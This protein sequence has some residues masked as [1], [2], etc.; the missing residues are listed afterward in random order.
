MKNTE[1]QA[2][3]LLPPERN[4]ASDLS[5]DAFCLK[6]RPIILRYVRGFGNHDLSPE[7]ITQDVLL[8]AW[9]NLENFRGDSSIK[10][11][12]LSIARR[13]ISK[14]LKRLSSRQS[15]LSLDEIT[16]EASDSFNDLSHPESEVD[17]KEIIHEVR[18]AISQLTPKQAQAVE[19]FY[20][21]EMPQKKAAKYANCP[22]DTFKNRLRRARHRLSKLLEHMKG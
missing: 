6:Y 16:E 19:L 14:R 3:K 15:P 22:F 20:F 21:K 13:C 4:L 11:Y 12:I 17:R 5:C 1:N 7:D 2:R 8:L 10:T 18:L 9:Q